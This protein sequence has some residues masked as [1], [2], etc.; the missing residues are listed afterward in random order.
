MDRSEQRII[1]AAETEY[2][3][4]IRSIA[5]ATWPISYAQIL[6]PEQLEYMLDLMYNETALCQQMEHGHTFLVLEQDGSPIGFASFE[7]ANGSTKGPRLHKLYVLPEA[8]GHG[9][10]H[11]LLEAV[12][13]AVQEH[14]GKTIDLNVNKFNPAKGFYERAGYTV[15]REEVL[16]IG[17][18]FVMDDFVMRKTL[19]P[20]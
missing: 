16:D 9:A 12:H 5:L 3:G 18:G 11:L 15:L 20:K 13:S 14:G 4:T 10:G 19:T 2:I 6:S 17:N 8:Q 1:H 7:L